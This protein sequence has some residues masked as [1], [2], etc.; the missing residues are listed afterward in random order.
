MLTLRNDNGIDA[1]SG[2]CLLG[3][4]DAGLDRKKGTS[5]IWR[6]FGD[7]QVDG[8]LYRSQVLDKTRLRFSC[9]NRIL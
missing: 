8:G 1:P 7:L 5:G 3:V 2:E 6:W 9:Y 4:S